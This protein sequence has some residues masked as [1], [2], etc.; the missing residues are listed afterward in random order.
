[1]SEVQEVDQQDQRPQL[2]DGAEAQLPAQQR[3]PV[4]IGARG[5]EVKTLEDMWR[6]AVMIAKSDLAP[7]DYRGKPEN[8][9]VAIQYG[10]E[11][12]IAPM[13][14]LQNVA[15]VNGRPTIF[16]DLALALV[17]ASGL[18]V[19]KEEFFDGDSGKPGFKA[20]CVTQRR[21]RKPY[22]TEFS[23]EDAK[24]AQLWGK[25]GPWSTNPKR[26]LQ[27][28]ARGFNL[29]DNFP[30]VLKGMMLAEE[31]I[32]ITPDPE[33]TPDPGKLSG[34]VERLAAAQ[35]RRTG[36]PESTIERPALTAAAAEPERVGPASEATSETTSGEDKSD[37]IA[38]IHHLAERITELT[39]RPG[40]GFAVLRKVAKKDDLTGLPAERLAEIWAEMK[41]QLALTEQSGEPRAS[42]GDNGSLFGE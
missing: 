39:G 33:P 30:D 25:Q 20:V 42:R 19:D 24:T 12:G 34:L 32:D 13:Q 38:E 15:V 40:A 18:L 8:V 10:M 36:E 11:L 22:R 26:M 35:G 2:K 23:I 21:G 4:A 28:R 9:A 31:V 3:A 5:I 7:K 17:E 14:A 29:R 16:G 6:F 1:M 37:V 41:S 27:M